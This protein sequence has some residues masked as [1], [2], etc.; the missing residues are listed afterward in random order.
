[1][2]SLNNKSAWKLGV[3]VGGTFTDAVLYDETTGQTYKAKVT[4][5]LSA[6]CRQW[7]LEHAIQVPST[8]HDQSQGVL[9]A[10]NSLR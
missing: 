5:V 2:Q 1:M 6:A 3:D 10:I 8:V 7:C 9:N 4:F